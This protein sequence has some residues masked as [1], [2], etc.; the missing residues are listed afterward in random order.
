[1][2]CKT[3][4]PINVSMIFYIIVIHI[5]SFGLPFEM[6]LCFVLGKCTVSWIQPSKPDEG[7]ERR[8]RKR[9]GDRT[10]GDKVI[11]DGF[12]LV[13]FIFTKVVL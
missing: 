6:L 9:D 10:H 8:K 12:V 5:L 4:H 7:R 11:Y 1:M 2:N 13:Q 3:E